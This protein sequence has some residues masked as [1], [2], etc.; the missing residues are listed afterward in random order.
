M[1]RREF[2]V[3]LGGTAMAWPLPALAQQS[4]SLPLVAVL[5]ASTEQLGASRIAS[6]R[7]GIKQ[8]GLVEGTD[9]LLELRFANGN[10]SRLQE[11]VKELDGSKPR[12]YV[13]VG[14]G[15][16]VTHQLVPNTPLVFTSIA[17]DPIALGWAQSY[18]R[19][20]GVITG[21]VQNAIG[22]WESVFSKALEL[23]K[24]IVPNLTRVG[25]VELADTLQGMQEGLRK[26]SGQVGIELASYPLRTVDDVE[27]AVAA[28]QRDGVSGFY[29][30]TDARLATHLPRVVAAIAKSNKPACGPQPIWPRGGLLMSYSTDWDDQARRAGGLVAKILRGAKPGDLPIEQADKFTLIINLKT[31]KQLGIAVP[32]TLLAQ[33]DEVIE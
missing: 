11:Y 10:Y 29:P 18:A 8:A 19:P 28:G 22:G 27:D 25:I 32:P 33:A 7:A 6:L 4:A 13:V 2:I 26:V 14:G 31:A 12:V 1:R 30:G 3:G 16:V 5:G 20:G 23:F 9:F 24:E 17:A 21:N 15:V